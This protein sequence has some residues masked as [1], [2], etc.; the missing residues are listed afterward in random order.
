MF[1]YCSKWLPKGVTWVA[2]DE[3]TRGIIRKAVIKWKDADTATHY[4]II[5]P[6]GEEISVPRPIA[7][8]AADYRGITVRI[9][10]DGPSPT[11]VTGSTTPS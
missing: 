6:C 4:R 7:G 3:T 2:A 9:G 10:G 11:S 8:H 1:M 5:C